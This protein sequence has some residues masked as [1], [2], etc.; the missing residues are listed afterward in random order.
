MKKLV[1]SNDN[2]MIVGVCGGLG[3]YFNIDPTIIRIIFIL[4]FFIFIG[5]SIPIYMVFYIIIPK[6]KHIYNKKN[7]VKKHREGFYDFSEFDEKR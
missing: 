3:I 2:K 4:S 1:L 6:E 7:N 5:A